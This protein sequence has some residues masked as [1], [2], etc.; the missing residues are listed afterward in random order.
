VKVLRE[1][2][3]EW[4]VDHRGHFYNVVATLPHRSHIPSLVSALGEKAF[5]LDGRVADGALSGVC[6]VPYLLCTGIP[7]LRASAA[8]VGRA[9]PP[10]VAHVPVALGEDP[11]PVLTA[12]HQILDFYANVPFYANMFT[13]AGF[14][15]NIRSA[16]GV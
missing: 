4:K 15:A 6:P 7:A 3:W 5:Q 8:A 9:D 16:G 10:L 13:N 11:G 2:I 1:S 14:A 12:G